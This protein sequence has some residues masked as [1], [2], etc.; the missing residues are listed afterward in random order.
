MSRLYLKQSQNRFLQHP[1]EFI[2]RMVTHS[3]LQSLKCMEFMEYI[4]HEPMDF[5]TAEANFFCFI[6]SWRS[7]TVINKLK[8]RRPYWPQVTFLQ[9]ATQPDYVCGLF[10][11]AICVDVGFGV[12]TAVV[13]KSTIF[14]NITPID[15][16]VLTDVSEEHIASI[17]RV[18]KITCARNQRE[19][20]WLSTLVSCSAY[21]FDPELCSSETSV[22]T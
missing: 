22:D 21:F 14:W 15:R 16:Q 18:E 11:K 9:Q 10:Y 17:F 7:Y 19:S 3:T 1:F 12:L 8:L 2:V 20:R 13:T 5:T 4:I 6:F